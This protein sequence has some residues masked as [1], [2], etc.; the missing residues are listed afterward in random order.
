MKKILLLMSAVAL[1]SS[2]FGMQEAPDKETL[3]SWLQH[4]Y[5]NDLKTKFKPTTI[6][7][8]ENHPNAPESQ[9][10]QRYINEFVK[11]AMSYR[12]A[13]LPL[14]IIGNE[15]RSAWDYTPTSPIGLHY[16]LT[17]EESEGMCC[18]VICSDKWKMKLKE[19]EE[20]IALK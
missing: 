6:A 15:F 13:E 3:K 5:V 19:I 10:I 20:K 18:A 11:N 16:I 7:F 12:K 9:I 14:N 2:A 1:S 8:L 17:G 4:R